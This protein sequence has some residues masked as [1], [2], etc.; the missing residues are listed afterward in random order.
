MLET[1]LILS[2]FLHFIAVLTL[3]GAALFPLYIFRGRLDAFTPAE[4]KLMTWL[5]WLL[6]A[7]VV[8]ALASGLGWFLFTAGS[9]AGDASQMASPA[10]MRS[11]MVDMDFGPLWAVRLGVTLV[12]AIF[13]LR[14]PSR[15]SLWLVPTLAAMTLATLA[16]T[17]HARVTEGWQG[18]LHIISDAAHLLAAGLWLGGLWPLGFVVAASL[19]RTMDAKI[20][21]AIAEV[22]HRFSGVATIT[23]AVLVASGLVNSWF[24]VGSPVVLL[25]STYGLLLTAKLALFVLMALLATANR[26][27][28]TPRLTASP[29][30]DELLK[31]LR[32]HIL[33]EQGLG[34]VVLALV[35]VLG[36]L[37]PLIGD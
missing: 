35:S 9:M 24:L 36:T 26:F 14:W 2:R 15:P 19:K 12:L 34:L 20:D 7:A 6:F 33:A 17:G 11:M 23:V 27:W 21:Q 31:R 37:E 30:S 13:L 18:T 32:W 28:L 10:V 1:G 5:R 29:S 25:S 16:G 3:F 8:L 4:V 22:L